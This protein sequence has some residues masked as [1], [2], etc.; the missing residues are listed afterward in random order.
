MLLLNHVVFLLSD[1]LEH[2]NKDD[3]VHLA[4]HFSKEVYNH[5]R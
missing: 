5:V 2:Q 3:Y 1:P 4:E